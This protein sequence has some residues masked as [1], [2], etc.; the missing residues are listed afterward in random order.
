MTLINEYFYPEPSRLRKE[1]PGKS[2]LIPSLFSIRERRSL[3]QVWSSYFFTAHLQ[4]HGVP[5]RPDLG[6]VPTLPI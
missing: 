6:A 4:R 2:R 5:S 3:L 1:V